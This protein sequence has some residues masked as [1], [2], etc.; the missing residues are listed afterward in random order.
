MEWNL[1]YMILCILVIC[2]IIVYLCYYKSIEAFT[3][4]E[5]AVLEIDRSFHINANNMTLQ[6]ESTMKGITTY[7]HKVNANKHI[8]IPNSNHSIY[9]DNTNNTQAKL[10]ASD[11]SLIKNNTKKI[12]YIKSQVEDVVH[13]QDGVI[14]SSHKK[15]SSINDNCSSLLWAVALGQKVDKKT[16]C[17]ECC[18]GS[19]SIIKVFITI[20]K[21]NKNN[22]YTISLNNNG[23]SIMHIQTA[24]DSNATFSFYRNNLEKDCSLKLIMMPEDVIRSITNESNINNIHDI[25]EKHVITTYNTQDSFEWATFDGSMYLPTSVTMANASF[26]LLLL[27]SNE[28]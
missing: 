17:R 14:E 23:F 3:T 1:T 12:N 11:V 4:P 8:Y 9:F 20:Q 26:N 22:S 5:D 18:K 27:E 21:D 15:S 7:D 16:M 24:S 10:S 28:N 13:V 6:G 2:I 19:A 25:T